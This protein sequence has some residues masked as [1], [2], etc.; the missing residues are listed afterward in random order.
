MK[1]KVTKQ[2]KNRVSFFSHG[3]FAYFYFSNLLFS[4]EFPGKSVKIN[5]QYT[6][7]LLDHN[8]QERSQRDTVFFP[9]VP[10]DS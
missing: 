6:T 7:G 3:I 5:F 2:Y 9:Q 10:G 4:S 8:L 1:K